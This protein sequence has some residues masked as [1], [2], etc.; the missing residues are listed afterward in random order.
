MR[1]PKSTRTPSYGLTQIT[2]TWYVLRLP[3]A[4]FFGRTKEA[5]LK[6]EKAWWRAQRRAAARL[7]VRNG[8]AAHVR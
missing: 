8:S 7:A 1:N 2:P 5:V 6:K 4:A 3:R